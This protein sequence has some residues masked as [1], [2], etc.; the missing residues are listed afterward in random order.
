LREKS[1]LSEAV[2]VAVTGWG[3][4]DYRR[5]SRETG[6]DLHLVKPVTARDLRAMLAELNSPSEKRY[7]K[8][9]QS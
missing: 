6:F 9:T 7:L 8:V 3:H 5:R 1:E 2:I 4:E